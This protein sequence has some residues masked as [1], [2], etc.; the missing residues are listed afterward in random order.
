MLQFP[1]QLLVNYWEDVSAHKKKEMSQDGFPQ[2]HTL[3]DGNK[4]WDKEIGWEGWESKE[5]KEKNVKG[6]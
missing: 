3:G 6:R 4:W 1:L 2:R 5:Y